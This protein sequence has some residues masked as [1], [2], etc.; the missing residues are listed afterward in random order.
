MLLLIQ[1][2]SDVALKENL[3]NCHKRG[4]IDPPAPKTCV[5]WEVGWVGVQDQQHPQHV[6]EA[7]GCILMRGGG[8]EWKSRLSDVEE[9]EEE[10]VGEKRMRGEAAA[11]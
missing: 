3:P 9:K 5:G 8:A 4:K 1:H 10:E 2:Q 7:W 6:W 11:T